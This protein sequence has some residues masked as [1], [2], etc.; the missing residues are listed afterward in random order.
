MGQ[1]GRQKVE[2]NFDFE[3]S[4]RRYKG[5]LLGI[6]L[7]KSFEFDFLF[8]YIMRFATD[9]NG[10]IQHGWFAGDWACRIHRIVSR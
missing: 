7:R 10:S 5:V 9:R 8:L 6:K 4:L 2:G 1:Q 3:K